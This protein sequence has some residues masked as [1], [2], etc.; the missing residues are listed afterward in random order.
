[1]VPT[2]LPMIR[3]LE[4]SLEQATIDAEGTTVPITVSV[5]VS[6]KKVRSLAVAGFAALALNGANGEGLLPFRAWT[7]NGERAA[8]PPPASRPSYC[9]MTPAYPSCD[10]PSLSKDPLVGAPHPPYLM[11]PAPSGLSPVPV[12][13]PPV[14]L[15]PP[16]V[17]VMPAAGWA[18]GATP[19]PMYTPSGSATI[20]SAA[21]T[22][23][24]SLP[25]VSMKLTVANVTKEP[26]L[27]FYEG[28][29][30][31]LVF[32]RKVPAGE[33]V[34]VE[35]ATGKRWVAIFA[36]N[37]SGETR[38]ASD[39]SAPWLLRSARRDAP[40]PRP[41]ARRN[42]PRPPHDTAKPPPNPETPS[43]NSR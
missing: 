42:V 4:K 20:A 19:T 16:N 41:A 17:P 6:A 8:P 34:D 10:T 37:P 26:A 9:P 15:Q 27:L 43:T 28:D 30:G 7:S 12:C 40:E 18:A 11:P 35:T 23:V 2:L 21:L 13:P 1:M 32:D 39:S 25:A 5:P 22:P 3:S 36:D 14:D 31:K 33:A 24:S 29:N 38:V